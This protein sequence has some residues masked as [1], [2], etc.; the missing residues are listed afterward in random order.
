MIPTLSL[1]VTK[2]QYWCAVVTSPTHLKV[3]I[4]SPI[5]YV[6]WNSIICFIQILAHQD[7]MYIIMHQYAIKWFDSSSISFKHVL[8][9]AS[10]SLFFICFIISSLIFKISSIEKIQMLSKHSGRNSTDESDRNL[11]L[12]VLEFLGELMFGPSQ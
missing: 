3:K 5:K 9:F 11:L 7:Y 10:L 4:T 12:S 2:F 8:Q 1:K 6:I